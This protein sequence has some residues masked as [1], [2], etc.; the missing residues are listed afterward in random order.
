MQRVGDPNNHLPEVQEWADEA[1]ESVIKAQLPASGVFQDDALGVL[2]QPEH[3]GGVF[4]GYDTFNAIQHKSRGWHSTLFGIAEWLGDIFGAWERLSTLAPHHYNMPTSY[5]PTYWSMVGLTYYLHN[6]FSGGPGNVVASSSPTAYAGP[7]QI[8]APSATVTLSASGSTGSGGTLTYSWRQTAGTIV[9]LNNDTAVSPTFTAPSSPASLA[10]LLTVTDALGGSS[11]DTV[12]VS[13]RRPVPA[14]PANLSADPGNAQ[15]ALSWDNPGD[16]SITRYEYRSKSGSGDWGSWTAIASSDAATVGV[17]LSSLTNER[18]YSFRVRA[19]NANGG[20]AASEVGPVLPSALPTLSLNEQSGFDPYMR[21]CGLW[22]PMAD[23]DGNAFSLGHHLAGPID[24]VGNFR[25]WSGAGIANTTGSDI[26]FW[27][28][29][30]IPN[31]D[32]PGSIRLLV[33]GGPDIYADYVSGRKWGFRLYV[34][35]AAESEWR[36]VVGGSDEL[37]AESFTALPGNK[38][39]AVAD[40]TIPLT[41]GADWVPWFTAANKTLFDVKIEGAPINRPPVAVATASSSTVSSGASVTL[42]GTGSSDPDSDALTYRW[43]QVAP[44]DG[45]HVSLSGANTKTATFTVPSGPTALAFKLTVTD[46][47]G[48]SAS[49]TVAITVQAP[50]D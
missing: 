44:G 48:A 21:G 30:Y 13:V 12:T 42:D 16:S 24:T 50:S 29:A 39:I 28:H 40:F 36:Y 8:V 7:D 6:R 23:F 9:T 43:E 3:A 33:R 19:V 20:G 11:S 49:D 25:R 2:C 4:N 26:H 14:P 18:A 41:D 10:F 34:K 17:T 46:T 47:Y 31:T 1:A 35:R 32:N 37:S 5:E 15:I 45:D 27:W 22:R 38:V